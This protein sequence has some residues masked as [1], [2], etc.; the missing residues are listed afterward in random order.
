MNSFC[1]PLLIIGVSTIFYTYGDGM[2]GSTWLKN[3]LNE[4][5]DPLVFKVKACS[6]A[7]ILLAEHMDVTEGRVYEVS[8]LMKSLLQS[9]SLKFIIVDCLRKKTTKC[10]FHLRLS[11]VLT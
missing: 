4:E 10:V 8:H 6:D 5:E 7:R 1:F 2:Y 3:W 9:R 11:L